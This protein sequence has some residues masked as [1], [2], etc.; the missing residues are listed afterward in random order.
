MPD[1][2]RTILVGHLAINIKA[3]VIPVPKKAASIPQCD[4]IITQRWY[5][6]TEFH[7]RAFLWPLIDNNSASSCPATACGCFHLSNPDAGTS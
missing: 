1:Q 4:H 7:H 5:E 2:K 6:L 3:G